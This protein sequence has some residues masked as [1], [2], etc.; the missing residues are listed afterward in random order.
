MARDSP[1]DIIRRSLAP[2]ERRA[3]LLLESGSP[4]A[5]LDA[6]L[7]LFVFLSLGLAILSGSA[8]CPQGGKVS[9]LADVLQEAL[10]RAD[11]ETGPAFW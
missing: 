3:E 10:A 1:R 11:S 7:G 5:Q 8:D 4:E 9:E 2:P 6:L